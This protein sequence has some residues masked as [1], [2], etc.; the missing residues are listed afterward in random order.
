MKKHGGDNVRSPT[1]YTT[2][3]IECIEAIE[4]AVDNPVDYYRGTCIKYLWRSGRKADGIED[5]RKCRWYIDRWISHLECEN[6][7]RQA[8]RQGVSDE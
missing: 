7:E 6:F 2:G 4:A 8:E 1:H 3:A 5:L